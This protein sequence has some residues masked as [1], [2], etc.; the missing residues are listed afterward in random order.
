MGL[1]RCSTPLG[2]GP[3]VQPL[4]PPPPPAGQPVS[5]EKVS[6]D[7]EHLQQSIDS[8]QRRLI[9]SEAFQAGANSSVLPAFAPEWFEM[10]DGGSLPSPRTC[11]AGAS[12]RRAAGWHG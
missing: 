2:P 8:L 4:P 1:G 9:D 6:E 10:D 3:F 12:R 7:L 5:F 11:T